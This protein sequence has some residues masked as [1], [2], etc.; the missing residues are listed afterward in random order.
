MIHDT[1]IPTELLDHL[2]QLHQSDPDALD[3]DLPEYGL[4]PLSGGRNNRVYR[5]Q[6][7]TGD[8]CLKLYKTDK[9]DRAACEFHA[10]THLAEHGVMSA[11]KALWHDPH[12]ELPAVAMTLEPGEPV[13]NLSAGH[14]HDALRAGVDVL[15]QVRELPLGYFSE[16]PRVDSASNY[17]RRI[18]EVWPKQL[19]ESADDPLTGDLLKLLDIW[20]DQ[21]NADV[22]AQ[23][24]PRVLSHGDANLL[25]WLWNS[26][27]CRIVDWEFTGYS[28]AAYDAAELIEH[29]SAHAIDDD[30]WI[31]LLPDLGIV[32]DS[33]R[34]RFLAAQ[35]T[36]S[37][38]W[39]SVLW[40]R[41]HKRVEEFDL[42][43]QRAE[44][45]LTTDFL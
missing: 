3:S 16:L 35:R 29:L 25:N 27:E 2:R 28:D 12:E 39:L 21:G 9:R 13:P 11:P 32:G 30:T 40:K 37:L 44:R 4:E 23:P 45:L 34:R 43:R 17:M 18:T 6:S 15:R 7:P 14:R 22:L 19:D 42:Q 38:R 10:L 24:A 36:V 31:S 41:R 5:W 1:A 33:T 26:E 8:I 20:R